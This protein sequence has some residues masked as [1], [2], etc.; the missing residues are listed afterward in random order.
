MAFAFSTAE[1]LI[2]LLVIA[3]GLML[4]LIAFSAKL[5]AKV[6][7]GIEAALSVG[8]PIVVGVFFAAQSW[9]DYREGHQVA[10]VG[11][12]VGAVLMVAL[13]VRGYRRGRRHT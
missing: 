5:P 12:A 3:V 4:V 11:Y 2:T 8:Y 10:T 6:R 1:W 9:N 7:R 13:A